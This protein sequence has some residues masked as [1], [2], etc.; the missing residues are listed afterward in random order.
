[1]NCTPPP[2]AR[3]RRRHQVTGLR[4][5]T[6]GGTQAWSRGRRP[7]RRP[8]PGGRPGWTGSRPVGRGGGGGEQGRAA[9]RAGRGQ[10]TL[11]QQVRLAARRSPPVEAHPPRAA[12][13]LEA[14]HAAAAERLARRHAGHG[15]GAVG[16]LAESL[17]WGK[18]W[19]LGEGRVRRGQRGVGGGG[20]NRGQAG[21]RRRAARPGRRGGAACDPRAGHP[22]RTHAPPSPAGH[23]LLQLVEQRVG[24]VGALHDRAAEVGAREHGALQHGV[25]QVGLVE[26]RAARGVV[27]EWVGGWVEDAGRVRRRG[28]GLQRGLE[29][30]AG[31]A[32]APRG[33][34]VPRAAF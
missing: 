18:G 17:L 22:P 23:L 27:R 31:C 2:A 12:A 11:Q 9:A 20:G 13:H 3:G 30:G 21:R 16:V 1:M 25:L 34:R 26:D 28:R 19:G 29:R 8:T 5:V 32:A 10:S 6:T 24:E 33:A 14:P 7:S 4:P 15:I